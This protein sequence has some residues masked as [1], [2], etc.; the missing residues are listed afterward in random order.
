MQRIRQQL[1]KKPFHLRVGILL[2]LLQSV[3][4]VASFW[5]IKNFSSYAV[6]DDAHCLSFVDYLIY[7]YN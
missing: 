1:N 2:I 5:L 3:K 6:A 4:Y 7:I